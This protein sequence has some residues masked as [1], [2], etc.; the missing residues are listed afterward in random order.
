MYIHYSV[1]TLACT[2]YITR[3]HVPLRILVHTNSQ[4]TLLIHS[5]VFFLK[6][7]SLRLR[8]FLSVKQKF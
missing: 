3:Y 4:P 7:P 5:C 6:E 2:P 8:L 1:N